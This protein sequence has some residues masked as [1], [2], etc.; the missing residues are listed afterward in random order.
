M[1][2]NETIRPWLL[3]CSLQ[4][5]IGA[6]EA[7]EIGAP[8]MSGKEEEI[9]F[10]YTVKGAQEIP[11]VTAIST[12]A[13]ASVYPTDFDVYVSAAQQWKTRVEVEIFNSQNGMSELAGCFIAAQ[14]D[15]DLINLFNVHHVEPVVG[16]AEV[17]NL[18]TRDG[19]RIYYHHKLTCYFHTIESFSHR[20]INHRVGTIV[21]GDSTLNTGD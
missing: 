6:V 9:Y 1:N 5:D 20:K 15:Q 7:F 18:S 11:K 16:S 17:Q 14:K 4:G 10:V 3:A 21:L 8:D 13:P 19:E 12:N 2:P